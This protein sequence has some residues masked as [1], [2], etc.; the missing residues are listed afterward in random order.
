MIEKLRKKENVMKSKSVFFR[1]QSRTVRLTTPFADEMRGDEWATEYPRP[2][3]KRKS[4]LSLCG[5]WTLSVERKGKTE[6]LGNIHVPFS[7][8]TALSGINRTLALGERYVYEKTF[9]VPRDRS[10]G[11]VFLHFGAVDQIAEVFLNQTLV[12]THTGGYLPFTIDITA[13]LIDGENQICVRVTDDLDSELAYGKQRRRRG[14]MW[15]TPISGIWQPVWMECVPNDPISDLRLT[16]TLDRVIVET[17]GGGVKKT[18]TLQTDRGERVYTYEGDRL[19]LVV[20]EPILWTPENP[21]LY[22]FSLTDGT[23]CVESY[24]ALRTV[25]TKTVDGIPR[26]CLNGK[27]YFF[28]GILDQGYYSDGIYLP[29]TPEGYRF[30]ISEMK[31]L[32][33]NM[34]RKHIKIEPE[35]FYYECDR[36]GM[37][38]FQDMVNSGTYNFLMDTALPTIGFKKGF[39]HRATQKRRA[40]FENDARGTVDLLYN[41]PCVCYYTIFNE[42]WGQYRGAERIYRELKQQDPTRVYDTASGWFRIEESDVRSEHIY[43]KKIALQAGDLPLILSEFGGYSCKIAGHS[44]HLDKTYGYRNC[45]D[46]AS[47][48]RDLLALYRTEIIP[49]IRQGLCAA[50]LTQVSDVE[51][52][53]NGLLTYDRRVTKVQECEMQRMAEELFRTFLEG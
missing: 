29:A 26:I 41:H 45:A 16:P 38:V 22:R 14:G 51:D 46:T 18:L 44:F 39:A 15:Y 34:L 36:Q 52:E 20:D 12:G 32:G 5:E 21:Y 37:I 27:P 28:H 23:D 1:K 19:E 7:P 11:S 40:N 3:M 31:K 30:D 33:F 49:A 8:E 13:F 43:F 25:E 17:V 10:D 50:V 6:L 48:E 2:Q 53:T 47:F 9:S 4:Y 42:G 24:F 35:I